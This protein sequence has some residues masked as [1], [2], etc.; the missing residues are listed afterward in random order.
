MAYFIQCISLNGVYGVVN[1]TTAMISTETITLLPNPQL[2]FFV[3]VNVTNLSEALAIEIVKFESADGLNI[4]ILP[5]VTLRT[6][7]VRLSQF[8]VRFFIL[9]SVGTL[10]II[11]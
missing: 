8:G 11:S 4:A 6:F 9:R 10:N 7:I 2:E 5:P 3:T 1:D